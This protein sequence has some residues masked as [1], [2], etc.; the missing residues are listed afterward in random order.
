MLRC[1]QQ[2]GGVLASGAACVRAEDALRRMGA[3]RD[4]VPLVLLL[5]ATSLALA[6]ADAGSRESNARAWL[7]EERVSL[8]AQNHFSSNWQLDLQHHVSVSYSCLDDDFVGI[9]DAT[10]SARGTYQHGQNHSLTVRFVGVSTRAMMPPFRWHCV[11]FNEVTG[12]SA[13]FGPE[14]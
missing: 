5:V 8:S 11:W 10:P 7:Q 2:E 1:P 3:K 13:T 6:T 12:L 14:E 4:G 9:T